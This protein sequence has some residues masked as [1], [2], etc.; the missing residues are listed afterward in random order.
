M[1]HTT[2]A[3]KPWPVLCRSP[4][5]SHQIPPRVTP[6]DYVFYVNL[7]ILLQHRPHIMRDQHCKSAVLPESGTRRSRTGKL[8]VA[9]CCAAYIR[10][11]IAEASTGSW[12]T[13][14]SRCEV[15]Y[16]D[17]MK[18]HSMSLQMTTTSTLLTEYALLPS[19]ETL[20]NLLGG[21]NISSEDEQFKRE[22]C[23]RM[24]ANDTTLFYEKEIILYTRSTSYGLLDSNR[25]PYLGSCKGEKRAAN[26]RLSLAMEKQKANEFPGVTGC[27]KSCGGLGCVCHASSSGCLFYRIYGQ[28]MAKIPQLPTASKD[29]TTSNC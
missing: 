15:L 1:P 2:C 21:H 24:T 6:H 27:V 13:V 18:P 19:H 28:L 25:F 5:R 11:T 8:S 4:N 7:T 29:T 12:S 22:T 26:N 9:L 16:K 14:F 17:P 10:E 23:L 20:N 3:L